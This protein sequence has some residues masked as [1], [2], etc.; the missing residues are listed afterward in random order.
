MQTISD[1]VHIQT[2]HSD[3]NKTLSDKIDSNI[4][5]EPASSHPD[6]FCKDKVTSLLSPLHH[7]FFH[8]KIHYF[9]FVFKPLFFLP[10]NPIF[11]LKNQF[12]FSVVE[13]GEKRLE[14]TRRTEKMRNLRE[15]QKQERKR[16]GWR[17]RGL[18]SWRMRLRGSAL[19]QRLC[20]RWGWARARAISR[21][22]RLER[23]MLLGGLIRGK[24]SC[25]TRMGLTVGFGADWVE[26]MLDR[27]RETAYK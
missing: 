24:L 8:P 4:S 16:R 11:S 26:E 3:S 13:R 15:M 19:Q 5:E 25:Y 27:F 12:F 1:L 2:F 9:F 23:T 7:P 20:I 21:F 10:K 22:Q 17:G 14:F 6:A 18:W